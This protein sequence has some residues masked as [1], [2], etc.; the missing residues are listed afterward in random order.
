VCRNRGMLQ[1]SASAAHLH[2]RGCVIPV[3]RQVVCM[4]DQNGVCQFFQR[5]TSRHLRPVFGLFD[6]TKK[7]A[8]D[9][10]FPHLVAV[11]CVQGLCPHCCSTCGTKSSS[12]APQ[13]SLSAVLRGRCRG[14][15]VQGVVSLWMELSA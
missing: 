11:V 14:Q 9:C 7:W 15:W 10:S 5:S 12:A 2:A 3:G 1:A 6:R 13:L 8:A 4:S